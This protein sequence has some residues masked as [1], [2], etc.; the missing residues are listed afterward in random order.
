MLIGAGLSMAWLTR[1]N[2]ASASLE[3]P[4]GRLEVTS[5][6]SHIMNRFMNTRNLTNPPCLGIEPRGGVW[7]QQEATSFKKCITKFFRSVP[8]LYCI[9]LSENEIFDFFWLNLSICIRKIVQAILRGNI[10]RIFV[11][12]DHKEWGRV[13]GGPLSKESPKC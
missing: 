11:W 2:G 5:R 3:T 1:M 12:S 13:E 8:L 4:K 9:S 6:L 10:K 7:G